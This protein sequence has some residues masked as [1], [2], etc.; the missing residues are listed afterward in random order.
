MRQ[1]SLIAAVTGAL[2]VMLTSH[3]ATAQSDTAVGVRNAVAQPGEPIT[4][5]RRWKIKKGGFPE[6]LAASQQGVWPFFEKIGAR[7]VGM[8]QVINVQPDDS[9]GGMDNAGYT[10]AADNG[11][12]YDEVILVTR[13]ASVEHWQATRHAVRLGGNGPDYDALMDALEVRRGLTIE[14]NLTFL[15]GFSGPNGPY[16]LPGTGET[17]KPLSP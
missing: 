12:E 11:L 16:F 3:T 15:Q 13:Y 6:F 2:L 5:M 7:V 1:M 14:T 17:F 10:Q 9:A 4:T 8:W